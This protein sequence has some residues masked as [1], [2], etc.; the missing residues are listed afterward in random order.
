MLRGAPHRLSLPGL[1][2]LIIAGCGEVLP[3]GPRTGIAPVSRDG[4][5]INVAS[6]QISTIRIGVVPSAPEITVGSAEGFTIRSK[7]SGLELLPG[8]TGDVVVTVEEAPATNYRLQ[9]ICT[10]PANRDARI[11]AAQAYGYATL[12]E[13][14]AAANCWRVY[15]GEFAS[16]APFAI[17]NA[18]RNEVIA[19]GLAGTDSFWRL[20]TMPGLVRYGVSRGGQS[21]ISHSAVVATPHGET[22]VIAGQRYRGAAEL[23]LNSIGKLAGVN[24]LPIEEYLYGVVPRELPPTIWAQ[25]EAQKA[26]AVAARTYALSNRGKRAA[27][28]YDLLPT[29]ADQVY[30]GYAAEHPLSTAA[31]DATHGMA[32]VADGKLIVTL[33]HST[34]GG[35][36]A[37]NEDVYS[38][39]P[40]SYLR[41]V[42]DAHRGKALEHVPSLDVFKRHANPTNL[43]AAAEGDYESDWSRYHRWVVEWSGDEMAQA[44]SVSFGVTVTTVHGITVTRRAEHGR[45]TEIRFGTDAGELI[46]YKDNI[47][48]R[49]PYP[50]ANGFSSLRSTLFFIEPVTDPRSKKV[51]GWK[52]YGGGWGHGVG[53]SQTGAVGM[54]RHGATFEE[55]L[56]HY[57]QGSE[58]TAWY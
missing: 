52:A 53:M 16:T 32:A 8:A 11:A 57:Y 1:L 10:N 7:V 20:V 6:N 42:P 15:L 17:R 2:T 48:S 34:S 25:L 26:Q 12:T 28:G 4:I 18:F 44:L 36:T 33:Y 19:R 13:F 5:R 24:E 58:L 50:T 56:R 30:G 40:I 54:A 23:T 31:V 29:T 14:V 46:A 49:L 37:N 51:T 45:V 9:V 22:I 3:T 55:I 47:R 35:W 43:R 27:D 21:T 38:S 39:A 41:G